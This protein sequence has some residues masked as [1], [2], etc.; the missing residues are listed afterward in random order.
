VT[1]VPLGSVV[2]KLLLS[3]DDPDFLAAVESSE[4]IARLQTAD[5]FGAELM[6]RLF[7]QPAIVGTALRIPKLEDKV[8]FPPKQV[9]LWYGINGHGKSLITS[10]V[11]LDMALEGE[12][13]LIA[14]FEMSPIATLARMVKQSAGSGNP[15]RNWAEA[16][17][18]WAHGRVWIYNQRDQVPTK[19]LLD[20][21]RYAAIKHGIKH[22]VIDSLMKCVRGEDDYDGQK[23]FVESLCRLAQGADVHVH[24]VHH[25]RKGGDESEMP[26]KF[27]VKGSGAIT[28]QVDCCIGV[29]RNKVK[30]EKRRNGKEYSEDSPD[31]VLIIDKNR[32]I[33]WEGKVGL[34]YLP[35]AQAYTD[36]RGKPIR[37]EFD[38]VEGVRI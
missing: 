35:G 28:D 36:L 30:E 16:F 20:L 37:Y 1:Y 31:A 34:Y 8:R 33:E 25:V 26:N 4:D 24:L 14:S 23:S 21:C 38:D 9:T 7:E 3:E 10:Q 18:A 12:P 13:V 6:H 19:R 27:A 5:T 32:H 15:T 22:I 2:D 17:L 11:A 29:W